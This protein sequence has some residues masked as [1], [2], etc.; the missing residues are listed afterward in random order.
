[1]Q[2][3]VLFASIGGYE[4]SLSAINGT[5]KYLNSLSE[6]DAK[7]WVST[8]RLSTGSRLS[9]CCRKEEYLANRAPNL[10]ILSSRSF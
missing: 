1:M 3:G 7:L 5:L 6:E 4:S 10:Q 2:T 8:Y 9:E